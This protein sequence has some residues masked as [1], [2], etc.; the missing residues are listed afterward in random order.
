MGCV[1]IYVYIDIFIDILI[2]LIYNMFSLGGS[3]KMDGILGTM[4]N[5]IPLSDFNKGEA[6]KIF[7]AIKKSNQ[8]KIVLRH[9]RPECII[10]STENY[11]QMVEELE[12][13]RDYKLAVE[14]LM[15]DSKTLSYEEVLKAL[16]MTQAEIDNVE[17]VEFE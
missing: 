1:F 15:K 14:R 10:I 16:E 6:G 3:E 5:L 4:N 11:A 13:L 7:G 8:P 9:N 12:D 17:D 2:Y